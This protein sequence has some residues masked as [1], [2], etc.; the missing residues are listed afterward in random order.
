MRV[1]GARPGIVL[2]FAVRVGFGE[3]TLSPKT[4]AI[5]PYPINPKP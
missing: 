5:K 3:K 4:L 2:H 1:G